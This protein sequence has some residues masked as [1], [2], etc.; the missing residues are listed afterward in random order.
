M[1]T[2]GKGIFA[3]LKEQGLMLSLTSTMDDYYDFLL[4]KS[5]KL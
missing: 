4:S 1:L 5:R 2:S 3:D